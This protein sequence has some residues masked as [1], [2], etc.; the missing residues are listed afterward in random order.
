MNAGATVATGEVLLFLHADVRLP[1][2]GLQ[3]VRSA[4]ARRDR[5]GGSFRIRFDSPRPLLGAVAFASNLRSELTR[6]PAGDRAIFVRADAFRALGGYRPWALMEDLDLSRRLLGVG[7]TVRLRARVTASARRFERRGP[8]RTVL[9]M[10]WLYLLWSLGAPAE[11]LG[12]LYPPV[13]SPGGT[14]P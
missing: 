8:L 3:A 13:P 7:P 6:V 2:R 9:L 10:A 14:G 1:P 12:R 4:M 11:G 5:V